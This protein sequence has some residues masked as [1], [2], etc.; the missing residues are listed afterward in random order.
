[1][2][3]IYAE[4]YKL[5]SQKSK[6]K[7]WFSLS[8]GIKG[9]EET[10]EFRNTSMAN[11][12]ISLPYFKDQGLRRIIKSWASSPLVR[13]PES[14]YCSRLKKK[15]GFQG[16]LHELRWYLL[17]F[18]FTSTIP[19]AAFLPTVTQLEC[20]EC[21]RWIWHQ[22]VHFGH[23]PRLR[24]LY[25]LSLSIRSVKARLASSWHWLESNAHQMA[26]ILWS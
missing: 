15:E 20:V 14:S 19:S 2:K 13:A 18:D 23:P 11:L 5:T 22:R 21:Y 16:C 12:K 6:K 3:Q 4:S 25:S 26:P 1:M 10:A 17:S 7:R 24:S 8:T 9:R